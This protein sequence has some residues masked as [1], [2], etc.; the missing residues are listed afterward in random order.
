[1]CNLCNKFSIILAV[2]TLAAI[3]GAGPGAATADALA[4]ADVQGLYEGTG[5]D[6]AGE[7]RM[8]VRVVAQGNGNY[9]V[10]VRQIRDGG[11]I[12]RAELTGK[13]ADDAVTVA[14]KTAG[15]VWKGVYAAGVIRGECGSSGTF[16]IR[17]VERKSPTLG[18]TPPPGAFVLLDGKNFSKLVRA[19]GTDIHPDTKDIGKDG[20]IQIPSGGMNSRRS[21]AGSLDLHV[22]FLI[23]FMPSAHGQGR[24][25]SGVFL[26]NGDEIQVLDSF[27]EPTYLGGGCGGVYAYA[28]PDVMETI[29]SL[30]GKPECKF[31]L[32]SAP[33]L[34]WQTY[35]IEYRVETTDGKPLGKPRVTVYHNGIKIHENCEIRSPSPGESPKGKL[36][37]QDHGNPVR[38]RN[39]WVVPK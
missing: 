30:K 14:G 10:F 21:F 28:D 2:T 36:H 9:N 34:Q 39:I 25:N 8:E 31:T 12:T 13:T 23:P 19:N 26:P 37:F 5:K 16:E 11:K 33:P 6:A 3:V 29:E 17:R 7:F 18:K 38:F 20:S 27:G 15:G 35:D 32:A 22:E 1:M 24:G 4:E